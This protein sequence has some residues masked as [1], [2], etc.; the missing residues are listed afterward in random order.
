AVRETTTLRFSTK[1]ETGGIVNIPF[2]VEQANATEMD[3]TFWIME[4][5]ELDA[6]GNPRLIMA[7][8]QVV[9]LD[10]FPQPADPTA[11]VTWPH[12]SINM[13][14]RIA[15]EEPAPLKTVDITYEALG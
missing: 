4:L 2:V 6:E 9:M 3:V 14:E 11:R 13:M 1:I 5:D 15:S 8:H 12:C 10:F 7:Y